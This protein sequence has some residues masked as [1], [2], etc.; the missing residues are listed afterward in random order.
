MFADSSVFLLADDFAEDVF[1]TK[2]VRRVDRR[3]DSLL[4]SV[5]R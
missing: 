1:G 5:F 4:A 2:K 3:S